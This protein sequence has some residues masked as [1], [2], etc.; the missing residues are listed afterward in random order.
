MRYR[1]LVLFSV[2]LLLSGLASSIGGETITNDE[3]RQIADNWK[4]LITYY[5]G[6]WN[7]RVDATVSEIIEFR[8]DDRLLGYYC[9]VEPSGYIIVSAVKGLAPV[10]IYSPTSRLDL[11]D[12]DGPTALFRFQMERLIRE[13][14]LQ[15][16]PVA[17]ITAEE[18]DEIM[19]YKHLRSLEMLSLK[20]DEFLREISHD[21]NRQD[22]IEE[23]I[24]L[25]SHWHQFWPYNIQ[26]PDASGGCTE[27]N[28]AVGC[29]ATAAA[30]IMRYWSWPPGRSWRLMRDYLNQTSP[31]KCMDSTAELCAA[32]GAA[33]GM[34]YCDDECASSVPTADMAPV[35][36]AWHYVEP[37]IEI[38]DTVSQAT[39]WQAIRAHISVNEPIQY[40]IQ[41]HSMVLDGWREW[42]H[43][44]YLPE[45]HM[46]YGW[47]NGDNAWYRIDRLLQIVEGAT[48]EQEYM[49]RNI[50]PGGS[51]H[52]TVSGPVY[53]LPFNYRYVNRDCT[54]S[55]ADFHPG[56]FIQF[57][58][59]VSLVC[60]RSFMQFAGEPGNQTYLYT[61][62]PNRGI[63]IDNGA[64]KFYP[65]SGIRFQQ[66]RPGP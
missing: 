34:D 11:E 55:A 58:P 24:L 33:V 39:W 32:L 64:I 45:Y 46:N 25:S 9:T 54:A 40:R 16:G 31:I 28:C 47:D 66:S 35:Y 15:V 27:D 17:E 41:G 65:G 62:E 26:V 48:W 19:E 4:T 43:G 1:I 21:R 60:T 6:E 59:G 49:I 42:F 52:S 44:E 20:S 2:A 30:Q 29:V 63:R 57:L 53:K 50:V 22:Y 61:P 12:T 10:K 8:S 36:D 7:G 3:A 14:E 23:E 18:V 37:I 5:S 51:L 13:V 56:Q 38:R